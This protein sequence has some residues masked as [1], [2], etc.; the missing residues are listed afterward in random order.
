MVTKMNIVTPNQTRALSHNVLSHS[1]HSHNVLRLSAQH[2]I[3][4][5]PLRI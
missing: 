5:R 1:V 4:R 2:L 3:Q